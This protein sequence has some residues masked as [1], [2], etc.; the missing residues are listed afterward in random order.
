MISLFA[1]SFD[2]TVHLG[3]LVT[4]L[5]AA[6]AIFKGGVGMRDA[7]RDLNT[8]TKRFGEQ[9]GDH[10]DRIRYLEFGDRRTGSDRRRMLTPIE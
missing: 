5:S 8:T 10:E 3:E 9:L 4:L 1:I 2:T 6:I 7:V